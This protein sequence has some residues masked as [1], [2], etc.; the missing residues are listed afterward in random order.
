VTAS[1]PKSSHKAVN[2][3]L[4]CLAVASIPA[5]GLWMARQEKRGKPALIPNSADKRQALA[6]SILNT[7]FQ[8]GSSVGLGVMA[9][10]SSIVTEESGFVDKSAPAALLEGYRATFW[11]CLG[12]S[13]LSCGVVA[14]GLR[15]I[16]KV[17]MKAG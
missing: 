7:A 2:V 9:A 16:G 12:A 5:F 3:I 15:G 10:V 8:F 4:F 1:N 17:G 6:G 13:A 14:F 11:T